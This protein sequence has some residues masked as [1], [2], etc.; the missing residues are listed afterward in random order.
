MRMKNFTFLIPLLVLAGFSI[1]LHGQN[2]P[3]NWS[4]QD[5]GV[6][7]NAGSATYE[8]ANETFTI[9]GSGLNFWD[10]DDAHFVYVKI[11]GDFTFKV[12]VLT[13]TSP[14]M[15]GSAKTG[16]NARN[17]L[18]TDAPSIMQAWENW[19]G[20]A[21]TTRTGPG[22]TPTWVG[23]NFPGADAIPWYL[24]M[25]RAGDQFTTFE[26][27]NDT[28]WTQTDSK[29]MTGMLST[30][31]VGL[32]ISPNNAELATATFDLVD[33]TGEILA[34]IDE[35]V[36]PS[37]GLTLYP[38]PAQDQLNVVYR[39]GIV[40]SVAITDVT[41]RIVRNLIV[42]SAEAGIDVNDLAPGLYYLQAIT[43]KGV[44]SRTFIRK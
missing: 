41:G 2:L 12:R 14:S 11:N 31:Y 1:Q 16:I 5:I 28:T 32:A 26:S 18:E 21:T 37:T 10:T 42:E 7:P 25:V 29:E 44:F 20:L 33:I 6:S 24:K 34:S 36:S 17:S 9:T 19:G 15:G 27:Y 4:H 35:I 22:I 23:A 39:G 38:N 3:A 40:Q 30:I 8:Q 13:F 43:E